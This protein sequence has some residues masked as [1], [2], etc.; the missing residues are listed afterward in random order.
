MYLVNC[1]QDYRRRNGSTDQ[2]GLR[3]V[4]IFVNTHR[5]STEL[6]VGFKRLKSAVKKLRLQKLCV[7]VLDRAMNGPYKTLWLS[8]QATTTF[9]KP[10]YLRISFSLVCVCDKRFHAVRTSYH[11]VKSQLSLQ[12][13]NGFR[14]SVRLAHFISKSSRRIS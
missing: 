3:D 5:T 7:V 8:L 6:T 12:T 14:T 9:T 2:R 13:Q 1:I 11:T 10:Y 4:Q